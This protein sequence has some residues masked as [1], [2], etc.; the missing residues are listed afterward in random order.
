MPAPY[1]IV[2]ESAVAWLE[3]AID[4]MGKVLI[5]DLLRES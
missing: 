1:L 3:E 4:S 5:C 2:V